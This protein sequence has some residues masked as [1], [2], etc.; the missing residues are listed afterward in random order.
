M[1]KGGF[2]NMGEVFE[3]LCGLA[4]ILVLAALAAVPLFLPTFRKLYK[5]EEGER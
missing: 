2:R 3:V 1:G 5:G 4:A